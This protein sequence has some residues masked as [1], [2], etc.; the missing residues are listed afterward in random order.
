MVSGQGVMW[1]NNKQLAVSS[2]VSIVCRNP[3]GVNGN[4]GFQMTVNA[5]H[6]IGN[7][8]EIKMDIMK[9]DMWKLAGLA[10]AVCAIPVAAAESPF[11]TVEERLQKMDKDHDGM[12]TVEEVR[13][14]I[15]TVHGKDFNKPVMDEMVSAANSKS[16][17]SPFSRSFY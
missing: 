2:R 13:A 16:C 14:Y 12:V 8:G 15:E 17:G 4:F 3:R 11:I 6:A 9:I 5:M 10:L 1:L 7:E